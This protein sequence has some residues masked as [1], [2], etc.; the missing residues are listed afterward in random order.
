MK[1]T[2]LP[3]VWVVSLLLLLVIASL[4]SG[5]SSHFYGIA[6]D[7]EQTISFEQPVKI[8]KTLVVEGE[9]VM[10]GDLLMEV[11]RESLSSN[12]AI[13][14]DELQE[15]K[16][17]NTEDIVALESKLISLQAKR[18]ALR[19]D[20]DSQIKVLQS[21]Y[22]LNSSF[23]KQLAEAESKSTSLK[24]QISPLLD[25]INGLKKQRRH[26]MAELQAEI[27]NIEF[28]LNVSQRPIHSQISGLEEKKSELMRQ[29]SGLQIRA[30]FSGRVGS[31]LFKAGETISPYTPILTVHSSRPSYVKAYINENVINK[32][33]LGQKV[34]VQSSTQLTDE[35]IIIGTVESL[36]SRIVEYP[37]RLKKNPLV[38]A[39][40]REV[41]VRLEQNHALLL[42][43]KV[44]VQLEKPVSILAAISASTDAMA[45]VITDEMPKTSIYTMID[46][47]FII[48]SS[49]K[50]NATKIEASGILKETSTSSEYLVIGDEAEKG[51][52]EL[53]KMSHQGVITNKIK[54]DF[55]QHEKIKIDDI[56]S[57][58][59]DGKYIYL[60]ASLSHNKK[61]K[62]K[63]KRRKLI[64]LEKNANTFIYRGSVDLYRRLEDLSTSSENEKVKDFL[65]DAIFSKSIDIE[66]H[67][68]INGDLYLGFK[69]PLNI[70][71]ESV[72]LKINNIDEI[73]LDNSTK[74]SIWAELKLNDKNNSASFISDMLFEKNQLLLLSVNNNN[75]KPFS[76]L[77]RFNMQSQKLTRLSSFE[78]LK[79][80]GIAH[81]ISG[82]SQYILV[83]DEDGKSASRHLSL[84]TRYLNISGNM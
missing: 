68:V 75:D 10:Q 65:Q 29:V 33:K 35:S 46:S 55:Q 45:D 47:Y 53:Y 56:E 28:Q 72:I 16:S 63:S 41:V 84:N 23:V 57:I 34:W 31:L 38:S 62:L 25:E 61:G 64:R 27:G 76:F 83:F 71:D 9:K 78:N 69:T 81:S 50:I 37:E 13:V 79:A 6:D 11:R 44:I 58:S 18:E 60:A 2:T 66:A 1:K 14:A 39:W 8:V 59:H 54:I 21:R 26:L 20:M 17:R 7:Q 74:A 48:T 82:G 77:W 12:L 15:L 43:E 49:D 67:N 70:N 22:E 30:N 4:I 32:V 36:G 51:D 42:G 5:E 40:G 24:L 80:E 73:F 19:A 3:V 52:V